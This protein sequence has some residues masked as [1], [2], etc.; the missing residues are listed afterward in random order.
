MCG[1]VGNVLLFWV[2]VFHQGS[3]NL[4]VFEVESATL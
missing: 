4:N 3:H 2:I 1:F